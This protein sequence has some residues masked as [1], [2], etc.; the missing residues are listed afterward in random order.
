VSS[1]NIG[2]PGLARGPSELLRNVA[3]LTQGSF[4]GS[5][6]HELKE[7]DNLNREGQES[8]K[9]LRNRESDGGD[10]YRLP[11]ETPPLAIV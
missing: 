4:G 1:G 5:T 2:R 7:I 11:S 3:G 8:L 10:I 6:L 9:K